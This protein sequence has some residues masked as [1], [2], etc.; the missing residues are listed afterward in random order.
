MVENDEIRGPLRAATL[1]WR[2]MASTCAATIV[3]KATFV[4]RPGEAILSSEPD[5]IQEEDNHWNDDATRSVYAPCDLYPKKP[6]VDVLLVGS[7]FAPNQQPAREIVARIEVGNVNKSV[8]VS[9][10]RA[11]RPDGEIV[12]R[13]A[14]TKMPL[15]YERAAGGP[16]TWNPVGMPPDAPLDPQGF[17]A[18]PNLEPLD[19]YHPSAAH[20]PEPIGFGP[21]A[22]A[23]PG[24]RLRAGRAAGFPPRDWAAAPLPRSSHGDADRA[25]E[26]N[27]I[28]VPHRSGAHLVVEIELAVAELVD[29]VGVDR[30]GCHLS[31]DIGKRQIVGSHEADGRLGDQMTNKGLRANLTVVRISP[32]Q[33]LV[34]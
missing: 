28:A 25:H 5:G 17:R 10:D 21:I 26:G 12:V 9:A 30:M 33:D 4:L 20:W 7:A 23:W 22:A 32:V 31:G 1:R 14:F 6:R 11:L 13:A 27:R 24:R 19:R 34:E 29:K 8:R 15:R 2:P 18:L 3:C 16:N